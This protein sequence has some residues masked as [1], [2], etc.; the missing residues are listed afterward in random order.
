MARFAVAALV[1]GL[2]GCSSVTDCGEVKD[3]ILHIIS[4]GV[5][6][7]QNEMPWH[8]G[9]YLKTTTPYKQICGGSI[10][11]PSIVISAA[12]CF[13]SDNKGVLPANNYAVAAGNIY[14]PWNDPQNNSQKADVES[15]NIPDRYRGVATNYMEDLAVLVLSKSF[16]Y[17]PNVSPITLDFNENLDRLQLTPGNMGKIVGWGLT[18]SNGPASQVLKQVQLPIV[19]FKQCFD[20]SPPS[21]RPFI[22]CDKFCA[23]YTDSDIA[24]CRGDSGGG[25][26]VGIEE[27]GEIHYYF[28]GV[29]STAASDDNLC[30]VNSFSTFTHLQ[31]HE[32][33]IKEY[34][35]D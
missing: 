5:T 20:D 34:L 21:F 13:W 25:L 24:V 12:H 19:S 2:L 28:R 26:V 17:A 6:V 7:Y 22:G 4:N 27:N 18:G 1:L 9:I 30:N 8:T 10:V 14:R 23:G 35:K 3:D 32:S 15:I 33:F 11:R 31:K 29:A 16:D